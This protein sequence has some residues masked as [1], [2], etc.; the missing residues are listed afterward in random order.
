MLQ[1]SCFYSKTYSSFSPIR[2]II[3]VTICYTNTLQLY[4]KIRNLTGSWL[5]AGSLTQK[6]TAISKIDRNCIYNS[7]GLL[8]VK[9]IEIH[10]IRVIVNT[11]SSGLRPVHEHNLLRLIHTSAR[12]PKKCLMAIGGVTLDSTIAANVRHLQFRQDWTLLDPNDNIWN[13]S[14]S[15]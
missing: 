15:H 14:G 1:S 12:L 2:E 10:I 3:W 13:R 8:P 9:Q 11:H 5:E 4:M 7:S 6:I